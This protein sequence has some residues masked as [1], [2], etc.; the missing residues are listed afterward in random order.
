[1]EGVSEIMG[2]SRFGGTPLDQE[3]QQAAEQIAP[4]Q[5]ET[6][7]QSAFGG[8]PISQGQ[9]EGPFSYVGD[10][11]EERRNKVSQAL[12]DVSE[13]RITLYEG[14]LR[15]IGRSAGGPVEIGLQT[16]GEGI[17][18]AN[19]LTNG[20]LAKAGM[21][22]IDNHFLGIAATEAMALGAKGWDKFTEWN[23]RAAENVEAIFDALGLAMPLGAKLK[24]GAKSGKV[25][26]NPLSEKRRI[27]RAITPPEGFGVRKLQSADSDVSVFGTNVPRYTN[28]TRELSDTFKTI[29]MAKAGNQAQL[30]VNAA[31][32]EIVNA[33]NVLKT[34]LQQMNLPFNGWGLKR[35]M[36]ANL[37]KSIQ[38]KRAFEGVS[39]ETINKEVDKFF[40]G[41]K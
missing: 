35:I 12:T 39:K 38:K 27:Q 13:G 15:T 33:S 22:F 1:M 29:P 24:S 37:K 3:P 20:G 30:N 36:K 16:A 21:H 11:M 14:A 17:K 19:E 8:T 34:E 6:Q 10:I 4:A 32:M 28:K 41:V 25:W 26:I 23:S 18:A 7:S 9:D 31:Q 40:D 5:Q 2:G